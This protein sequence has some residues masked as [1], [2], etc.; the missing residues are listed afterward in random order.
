LVEQ[1][2][3]LDKQQQQELENRLGILLGHLLQ[4]YYQPTIRTKIWW[5]A[6]AITSEL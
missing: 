6:I 4:W 1:I 2:D 3:C 5:G